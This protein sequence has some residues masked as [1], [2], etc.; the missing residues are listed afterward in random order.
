MRDRLTLMEHFFTPYTALTRLPGECVA[1]LAPHPDDEVFGCGGTLA[2]MAEAGVAIE[3]VVVSGGDAFGEGAALSARRREESR[4]AA[5]VLG[6]SPPAFWGLPDGA[7]AQSEVLA[8]RIAR[9]LEQLAPDVL[10]LPSTDEMH[11]DHRAV[12]EAALAICAQHAGPAVAFYEVGQ[13]LTPNRLVDIT[14]LWARKQAAMRCFTSQLAMQDYDRHIA[15][16]NAFRT[17]TLAKE[18]LAA[19][20]FHWLAPEEV[21]DVVATQRPARFS[22]ILHQAERCQ[23]DTQQRLVASEQ[24]SHTLRCELT[25]RDENLATLEQQLVESERTREAMLGSRSWRL[26]RGLRWLARRMRRA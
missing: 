6:Y 7:L 13:P 26:T 12:T 4:A 14:P 8:P 15:G 16:L 11:R 1:V 18:V 2:A 21:A 17:Y 22:Q 20:A 19:E 5:Q 3:V 10:L 23:Q 25:T 9:W 24:E